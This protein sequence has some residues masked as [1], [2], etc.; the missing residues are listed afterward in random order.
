MILHDTGSQFLIVTGDDYDR[1][2]TKPPLQ[3]EEQN[4]V[5][6]DGSKFAFDGIVY[7]N[8]LLSNKDGATFELSYEPLLVS[9]QVS[10]NIF[11]FNSEEKFTSCC[12][13]S[14]DNIMMF[15]TKSRKSLKAKCYRENIEA[16]TAYIR[17]AKS[18]V[19]GTTLEHL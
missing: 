6:I 15:T 10:S 13:N 11:C 3:K 2:P 1:P 18:T 5:G 14:E 9:S 8:L 16:T 17:I 7:L 12:R 19:V 4:G